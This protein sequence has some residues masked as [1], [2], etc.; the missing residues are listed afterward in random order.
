MPAKFKAKLKSLESKHD[1]RAVSQKMN[2]KRSL[3]S[4]TIDLL[5]IDTWNLEI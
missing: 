1:G 5:G 4:D 2:N 3:N